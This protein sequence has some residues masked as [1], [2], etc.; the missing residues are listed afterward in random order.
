MHEVTHMVNITE[1]QMKTFIH[2]GHRFKYD[3]IIVQLLKRSSLVNFL[4]NMPQDRGQK[5]FKTIR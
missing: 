2:L 5:R 1:L 4:C 3:P